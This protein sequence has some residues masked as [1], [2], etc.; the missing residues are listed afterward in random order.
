MD[1]HLSRQ[2]DPQRAA[3]CVPLRTFSQSYTLP[4][5]LIYT[6][7]EPFDLDYSTHNHTPPV[8]PLGPPLLAGP[9]LAGLPLLA[10]AGL[11]PPLPPPPPPPPPPILAGLAGL[12]APPPPPPP[13]LLP[14]GGMFLPGPRGPP[15]LS[16]VH[17]F[18]CFSNASGRKVRAPV[19]WKH[20]MH[21]WVCA[22]VCACM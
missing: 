15:G 22:C 17:T 7:S 10:L 20:N 13:G 5:Q 8:A 12:P 3:S 4:K 2:E 11:P 19:Y 18:L 16:I 1:L 6:S 14:W 21:M 9:G